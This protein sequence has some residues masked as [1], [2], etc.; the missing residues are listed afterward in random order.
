MACKKALRLADAMNPPVIIRFSTPYES[1]RNNG[2]VLDIGPKFFLF[3]IIDDCQ[4]FNGFQCSRISDVRKLRVP[5]PYA[6]F[7]VAALRKQGQVIHRKPEIDL[8]SLSELLKSAK[9]LFSLITIHRERMRPGECVIGKVLKLSRNKLLLHTIGPDAVWDEKPSE[10]R[11][12]DVTRVDF[13]GG[14][15]ESLH[16]VGGDPK[17]PKKSKRLR[18][19]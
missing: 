14:Y 19:L 9:A 12:R 3:A 1:G 6:D 13:G 18:K 5:A 17:Q 2:Y 4:K 8:S 11:L 10:F 7:Y 15:E 16:L